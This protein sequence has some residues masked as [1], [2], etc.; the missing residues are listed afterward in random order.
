MARIIAR[1]DQALQ[2]GGGSCSSYVANRAVTKAR[3][4]SYGATVV[5]T[6]SDNQ[7]VAL[8]DIKKYNYKYC[9]CDY[10]CNG[11]TCNCDTHCTC[12]Y[13]CSCD[14][15]H[16]SCN[17]V[18]S[19]NSGHQNCP[20]HCTCNAVC[21]C[22]GVCTCN[23]G[24]CSC[25]GQCTSQANKYCTCNA[26]ATCT[27]KCSCNADTTGGCDCDCNYNCNWYGCFFEYGQMCQANNTSG[28]GC[29]H[30]TSDYTYYC[31]PDADG[32][33]CGP[34]GNT[35]AGTYPAPSF[36]NTVCTA[37]NQEV[38]GGSIFCYKVVACTSNSKTTCIV[39]EL[40]ADT[41]CDL[42]CGCHREC[43][44][45]GTNIVC[46]THCT[47]DVVCECNGVCTCNSGNCSCDGQCTSQSTKYCTCNTQVTTTT[48]YKCK[49][50]TNQTFCTCDLN[51]TCNSAY[52]N[53]DSHC[54]CNAICDIN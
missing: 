19:C 2:I 43:V 6:Y 41:N 4:V 14:G 13:N 29:S 27:S 5:G 44:C 16:C 35:P 20:S 10:Q 34:Y 12:N 53:C 47:C 51:C 36:C 50:D 52:C 48:E 23:T 37:V 38:P 1:E 21:S 33:S 31:S 45:N 9:T 8:E 11:Q 3:A 26:Q 39:Y 46:K 22:N 15:S 17:T 42:H 24:N 32:Y 40:N 25:D 30:C 49:C 7:L 54:T 18:C 28:V